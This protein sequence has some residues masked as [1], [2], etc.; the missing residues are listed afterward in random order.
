MIPLNINYPINSNINN[1]FESAYKIRLLKNSKD[2]SNDWTSKE[3]FKF[4]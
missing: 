3:E 2:P 4:R 1:F